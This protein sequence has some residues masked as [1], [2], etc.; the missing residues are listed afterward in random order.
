MKYFRLKFDGELVIM[1]DDTPQL[2]LADVA[3]LLSNYD[4]AV[5]R[6]SGGEAIKEISKREFNES[7]LNMGGEPLDCEEDPC[8]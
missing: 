7:V 6:W 8:T 4:T 2:N 1:A 5:G 3:E